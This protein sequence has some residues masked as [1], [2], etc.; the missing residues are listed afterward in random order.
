MRL[1][2]LAFAFAIALVAQGA[3]HTVNTAA[4]TNDGVCDA[5]GC[6]LREA[7][8]AAN[9]DGG[10]TIHFAIGSG[11]A[12]ITLTSA[13]PDLVTPIVLDATTQPGYAGTPLV[14]LTGSSTGVSCLVLRASDS[15]VRGLD[16]GTCS[17]G[18]EVTSSAG[19]AIG[20]IAIERNFIGTRLATATINNRAILLQATGASTLS[21]VTIGNGTAAGRNV[22]ATFGFVAD[23]LAITG[24]T[25]NVT[26]AGNYFGIDESG[27]G[28][29]TASRF[30]T[31]IYLNGSA[32]S[33]NI[34]VGGPTAGARNVFGSG[35][36]TQIN[37]KIETLATNLT[38]E[39]NYI[40]TDPTG[41]IR[42]P[43]TNF[44]VWFLGEG[45]GII[46]NNVITA[47]NTAIS[48]GVPTTG[49]VIVTGNWIN[50]KADGS[51]AFSAVPATAINDFSSAPGYV[52][53]GP[54]PGDGNVIANYSTAVFVSSPGAVVEGNLI[55]LDPTGATV[56]GSSSRG[57]LT[58]FA[59]TE[60][61][62][63][64]RSN[65]VAGCTTG[66][67]VGN[68]AKATVE[69]NFVG[70]DAT[71]TLARPNVTGINITG[72]AGRAK[73][74][75]NVVAG[76]SSNGIVL[77]TTTM[78]VDLSGNRIGVG[79]TNAPL[80]NAGD[81]IRVTAGAAAMNIGLL[82]GSANTI[83]H[84]GGSGVNVLA[85]APVSILGNSIF[86]NAGLAIDLG[87]DGVTANDP[88]DADTGA[89]GLQNA[90]FLIAASSNGTTT[91]VDG[92]LLSS[93][94]SAFTI[95]VFANSS[96]DPSNHGEAQTSLARFNVVT[97]AGGV[98][99]FS[100]PVP[101]VAPGT[102]LSAT[103]TNATTNETSELSN[104][105]TVVSGGI[106]QFSAATALAGESDG[107]ITITVTR[108]GGSGV[109]ATVAYASADG[110]ATAGSDYTAVSGTLG[111]GPAETSKTFTVPINPDLLDE[112]DE[113][114][115]LQLS[116]ATGGALG[117]PILLSVTIGDDDAAPALSV[118]DPAVTEGSSGTTT[119]TFDVSL[120]AA[121]AR[122]ATVDYTTSDGSATSG[123]DY[124]TR[125][126]TLVFTPGET[127]KSVA[128]TING[129]L[130]AEA[131]ETLT[132]T[133]SNPLNA[134]LADATG[135][136][137]INNDDGDPSIAITDAAAVEGN[138]GTSN[139]TL[140]VSLSNPSSSSI[141]VDWSTGAT[142]ATAGSDFT[143]ASGTLTFNPGETSKTIAVSLLADILVEGN[144]SF[145]VSLTNPANATI[146][147]AQSVVTIVDD[148]GFPSLT[149]SDLAIEE[150]SGNAT[151]TVLLAPASAQAVDVTWNTADGS[152]ATPADYAGGG[153]LLTFNPGETS[154][155]VSV[156]IVGDN[157]TEGA[158]TFGVLLTGAVNAAVADGD[159][160]VTIVDDD[161]TPEI[162]VS[163]VSVIEGSTA[164]FQVALS[165]ASAS[166]VTVSYAT[167]G[168]TAGVSD[169]TAS[170]GTLT[171]NPG[172]TEKSVGVAT[173][174][175]TLQ[176]PDESFFFALS[177]ASGAVV[178]RPQATAT[179]ADDDGTPTLII[180][181]ASPLEGNAGAVNASFVVTLA[182]NAAQTVTVDY[183]TANG[184][185]SAGSDF[186]ATSGHLIFPP[187][188]STQTI[189]V[190]IVGDTSVESD[191]TFFINLSGASN[192]TIADNQALG[193]IVNDDT[194]AVVP[195]I[196]IAD[197]IVV[198]G[199]GGTTSAIFNVTLSAPTTNS[200]TVDFTTA[201][202]SA[203]AGSDYAT[204]QGTLLFAP[205][206]TS[207]TI[208]VAVAGDTFV[209]GN[210]S[211]AV[212]LSAAA[213]ATL[214][215]AQATGTITDDDV[216]AVIPSIAI[217][218]AVATE[219][220][221]GTS[222]MTFQVTLSAP[223]TNAVSVDYV[224]ANGSATAGA[225]YAATT[226]TLL[227]APGVTMQAVSVAVAG[228]T[229]AEPNETLVV[230]LADPTNATLADPQATGTIVDDDDSAAP[231][232][233]LS[234]DGARVEEGDS[235]T[236]QARFDVT[237]SAAA[238]TTI[239]VDYATANGTAT[240][241]SDFAASNGT[242]VFTPGT[243]SRTIAI[244]ILG[245][246]AA[247][248]NETFR[249]RLD[250]A[251]GATIADAQ[252]T[253][254]IVDDDTA[255][256]PP[257]LSIEPATVVEGDGGTVAAT[258]VVTLSHAAS[259]LVTVDYATA[260]GTAASGIDFS[261][262][263]GTL[264]FPAG[265]TSRTITVNVAGDLA[266]ESDET[267][268][269]ILT[270]PTG[271]TLADS[272]GIGT[273]QDDDTSR[274]RAL[275][276]IVG[277]GPGD[278][279]SF[280]RT[281]LQ[282]HNRTGDAVS[283]QLIFRPIG[284]GEPKAHGYALAPHE[285]RELGHLLESG[286]GT[287]D[288]APSTGTL[289]EGTM[290]VYNDGGADGAPGFLAPLIAVR[291]AIRAGE[292]G[293]LIAPADAT[294]LRYNL[295]IRSLDDGASLTFTLR[296]AA[297]TIAATATREL[298]PNTLIQLPAAAL[299]EVQ[300]EG[301]DAIEI[302]VQQGAA[303]VYGSAVDNGSQDPALIVATPLQ[304]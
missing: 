163:D 297:G 140:L 87:G 246:T 161:P 289:P 141:T 240:S 8:S 152:A 66:I 73:I 49:P 199:N 168:G 222:A 281:Q 239:T 278:R 188:V 88:G 174:G 244:A 32:T 265:E 148:D 256:V 117:T 41:T 71:G 83:A 291:S 165:H 169:F 61:G 253:G 52:I 96:A 55:N 145:A 25:S 216:A 5:A 204:A 105:V 186:A 59:R 37:F 28:L 39:G 282:L 247:E 54:N 196:A 104:D 103:A 123:S 68:E 190:P 65:R 254:T 159:A 164:T 15:L 276:V 115:N 221:S 129:D 234:I 19:T 102:V 208:V 116:N 119:M 67:E 43:A 243:T 156:P 220:N 257:A 13:L 162:A 144:E 75:G 12:S 17:N 35:G 298:P 184:T 285:T 93:P 45:E 160:T 110:T 231:L 44:A 177:G 63:F 232:P 179:I 7:V 9:A 11:P 78:P 197:A 268:T 219:G 252:A 241:G 229:L 295:G 202:G 191:E 133:L 91:T 193:T 201:D 192:A 173:T 99:G 260:S 304:K 106:I 62:V 77:N 149:I 26:V 171:F 109:P 130:T 272:E 69:D 33:S 275:F 271:A 158:E 100:T 80:P 230:N 139:A 122:Q 3:T 111:F 108:S 214:A 21:D 124:G 81:G 270:N 92:S 128:I 167:A 134:T 85:G 127:S 126:G 114:F 211:F 284:G 79:A 269:V 23:S 4:D 200:V 20:N 287:L 48:R 290:R 151:L 47:G 2:F 76:N 30:T 194:A 203:L 40:G 166:T 131:N 120:S 267:F 90:P 170:A 286:F 242:L 226:G 16:I 150:S 86:D 292:E 209:E 10:G 236:R 56:I 274:V 27:I 74:A 72:A 138:A 31:D 24:N 249:V 183:A 224:T 175:E 178:T 258:F 36:G 279:G 245:D 218:N 97:D 53:G 84:N 182:G 228:D 143:N 266:V 223:T 296:R 225:D 172:E 136:G 213:N 263:N 46:R 195:S 293:L 64:I 101:L 280:F 262:I 215:D 154:K 89:N 58:S 155:T 29:V 251:S 147:D 14:Q 283:G 205:G 277:S 259:V 113:T 227:F 185:G 57:I 132:L 157:V 210:E 180:G 18:I 264:V 50:L 98:A 94:G 125:F 255:E 107:T 146:A 176:E 51:G 288:V 1:T 181:D 22:L 301:N 60:P 273:I 198:E 137:T 233:S 82:A 38:I 42:R 212:N 189:D 187:G 237:L 70:T 235:G 153:A 135:S 207:R 95:E 302:A 206:A 217:A 121:S 118:S 238:S 248:D 299:F 142:S 294:A 112:P 300:L 303:I 6:S 34:V 250:N 261:P